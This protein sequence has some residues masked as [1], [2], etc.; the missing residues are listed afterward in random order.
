MARKPKYLLQIKQNY[1]PEIEN[2]A[3]DRKFRLISR[4]K[5][6]SYRAKNFDSY[7]AKNSIHIALPQIA[8]Y[9]QITQIRFI[10]QKKS[11]LR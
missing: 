3:L 11:P 7:R 8:D 6:D 4:H 10:L 1:S 9:F 5:F 2:C